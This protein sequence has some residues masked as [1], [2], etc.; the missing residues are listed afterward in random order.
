MGR[1]VAKFMMMKIVAFFSYISQMAVQL[2]MLLS[3]SKMKSM[4]KKLFAST[5]KLWDQDTL[6]S[7]DQPLLKFNRCNNNFFFS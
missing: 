5:R 7:L 1:I 6:S 2:V 4:A 3:S